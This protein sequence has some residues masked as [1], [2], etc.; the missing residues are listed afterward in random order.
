MLFIRIDEIVSVIL[1][2]SFFTSLCIMKHDT[3]I[4]LMRM[5]KHYLRN[6]DDNHGQRNT[7]VSSLLY[8][9][10]RCYTENRVQTDQICDTHLGLRVET[11]QPHFYFIFVLSLTTIKYLINFF[12]YVSNITRGR[13]QITTANMSHFNS[14]AHV[15]HPIHVPE[16]V[17][18]SSNIKHT[19]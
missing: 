17:R 19:D 14:Q 13:K 2:R 6:I 5:L 8:S 12:Y 16:H 9:I 7:I 18:T 10:E 1:E 4:Y 11:T 3:V 15:Q